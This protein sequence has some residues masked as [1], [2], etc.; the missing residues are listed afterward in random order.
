VKSGGL[1]TDTFHAEVANISAQEFWLFL[2]DRELF[3]PFREFPWFI[4]ATVSKILNVHRPQEDH[5]FLPDE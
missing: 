4:D 3:L 2:G 1:G 5:L